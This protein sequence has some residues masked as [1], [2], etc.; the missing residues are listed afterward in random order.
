[1]RVT[2]DRVGMKRQFLGWK[3]KLGREGSSHL[4]RP[5]AGSQVTSADA[6]QGGSDRPTQVGRLSWEERPSG[7]MCR[8]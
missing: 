3:E 1:M 5:R 2:K 6:A 4:S 7:R 8:T